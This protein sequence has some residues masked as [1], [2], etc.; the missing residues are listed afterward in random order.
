[1]GGYFVVSGTANL[2]SDLAEPSPIR[3]LIVDAVQSELGTF[4]LTFTSTGDDLDTG[5]GAMNI[6]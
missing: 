2:P 6:Y 3:D 5:T 1:M 4:N